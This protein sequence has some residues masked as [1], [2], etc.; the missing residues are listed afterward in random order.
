V[1]LTKASGEHL[2]RIPFL[3]VPQH[4]SIDQWFPMYVSGAT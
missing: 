2:V 1:V 4:S 3:F